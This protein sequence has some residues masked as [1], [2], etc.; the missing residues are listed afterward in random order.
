M[1]KFSTTNLFEK[2]NEKSNWPLLNFHHLSNTGG[3]AFSQTI[4]KYGLL[5]YQAINFNPENLQ[6]FTRKGSELEKMNLNEKIYLHGH[7]TNGFEKIIQ[8]P[9][10]KFTILRSPIDRFLSEFFWERR[11]AVEARTPWLLKEQLCR[12][13]D[14]LNE[15]GHANFYC[16]EIATDQQEKILFHVHLRPE[17]LAAISPENAYVKADKKLQQE[18]SY[19]GI[20]ELF[21]ESLFIFFRKMGWSKIGPWTRGPHAPGRGSA[22]KKFC[23]SDIPVR[24]LKKLRKLVAADEELYEQRRQVFEDNLV[25]SPLKGDFEEYKLRGWCES[26]V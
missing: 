25:N 26:F 11:E 9:F 3:V 15:A 19:V 17:N 24:Y 20:T 1:K 4:M 23:A 16:T 14:I 6:E 21:E 5:G 12:W 13:I 10:F 8:R 18:Y 7:W 22:S 2:C